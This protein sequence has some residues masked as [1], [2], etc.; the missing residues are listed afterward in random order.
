MPFSEWKQRLRVVKAMP[1]LEANEKVEHIS[2]KLGYSNA[3]AFIA[4][5]RRMT[6]V[7]PDEYRSSAH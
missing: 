4:M 7:T 1:R 3:S 6:G 5:F 2:A